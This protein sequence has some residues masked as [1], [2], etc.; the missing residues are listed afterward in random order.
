MGG[1]AQGGMFQQQAQN[2]PAPSRGG[3]QGSALASGPVTDTLSNYAPPQPEPQRPAPTQAASTLSGMNVQRSKVDPAF[4][5]EPFS[6]LDTQTNTTNTKPDTTNPERPWD[7]RE[8]TNGDVYVA[9]HLSDWVPD[10]PERLAYDPTQHILFHVFSADGN[11]REKHV[12][13]TKDMEYLT[14][15][16]SPSFPCKLPSYSEGEVVPLDGMFREVTELP[17]KPNQLSEE[18]KKDIRESSDMLVIPKVFTANNSTDALLQAEN[19]MGHEKLAREW[20]KRP[21]QV[22]YFLTYPVKDV[23]V[24]KKDEKD[25]KLSQYLKALFAS[26]TVNKYHERLCAIAG[27]AQFPRDL[28][29]TLDEASTQS[30]NEGLKYGLRLELEIDSFIE[31]WEDLKVAILTQLGEDVGV[32]QINMMVA[33]RRGD[34]IGGGLQLLEKEDLDEAFGVEGSLA[35][36]RSR[37]ESLV[38]LATYRSE[39][40]LPVASDKLSVVVDSD[41]DTAQTASALTEG[42]LPNLHKVVKDAVRKAKDHSKHYR[43]THLVT[44]DHRCIAV[45]VGMHNQQ[46]YLLHT[47]ERNW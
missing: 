26:E 22:N 4:Q 2:Q 44:T 17:E 43:R 5:S 47:V 32:E 29:H 41:D 9:A 7:R 33:S 19:F 28:L 14:H 6:D 42:L 46:R 21:V 18:R 45:E 36:Y 16:V 34:I 23:A 10:N 13:V 12:K 20:D 40:H 37:R 8:M 24:D 35:R 1:M 15:E 25:I 3:V 31:D 30:V 27:N 38:V 11:V 39:T